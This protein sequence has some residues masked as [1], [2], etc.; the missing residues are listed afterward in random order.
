M[1]TPLLTLAC[2]GFMIFGA[3]SMTGCGQPA[4]EAAEEKQAPLK[5]EIVQVDQLSRLADK[6]PD[7]QYLVAKAVIQNLSNQTI[8]VNPEDFALENITD[9]EEER[10]SQPVERMVTQPFIQEYGAAKQDKIVDI[11]SSNLYPR[12]QLERYMVF[13]VPV[14]AKLDQYQVTYTPEKVSAPLVSNSTIINDRRN[15]AAPQ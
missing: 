4:E 10:Y 11:G 6:Y 14:N 1:R 13:M 7:G 15:N 5:M 12:L 8:V 2:F 9:K 3:A